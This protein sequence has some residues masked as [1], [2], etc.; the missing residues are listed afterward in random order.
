MFR[1]T[2]GKVPGT[3]N[4]DHDDIGRFRRSK[5]SV[6]SFTF[7][8]FLKLGMSLQRV[9]SH[10]FPVATQFHVFYVLKIAQN[11]NLDHI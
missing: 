2:I 5:R 1:T 9:E 10:I 7:N 11:V 3:L 8:P 4:L 6:I